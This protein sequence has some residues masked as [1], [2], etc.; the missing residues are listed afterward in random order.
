MG[1]T[2]ISQHY[3][4]QKPESRL[5][6]NANQGDTLTSTGHG[7]KKHA[8]EQLKSGHAPHAGAS[9]STVTGSGTGPAGT[10]SSNKGKSSAGSDNKKPLPLAWGFDRRQGKPPTSLV[11]DITLLKLL[12]CRELEVFQ[13]HAS[14]TGKPLSRAT[15]ITSPD[16]SY[17]DVVNNYQV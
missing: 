1:A 7:V 3:G 12:S 4:Q 14:E 9:G 15:I 2:K 13:P 11:Q 6:P 10:P 17:E 16:F 5:F 8:D